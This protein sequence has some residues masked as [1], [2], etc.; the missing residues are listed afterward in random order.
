MDV[1]NNTV[2]YVDRTLAVAIAAK[3]VGVLQTQTEGANRSA[4]F[5]WL[6]SAAVGS[7]NT[8][9]RASD[10][11]ELLPEDLIYFLYPHIK[12]R[13]ASVEP[14]I[15]RLSSGAGDAFTPGTPISICGE[16]SFPSLENLPTA[17]K[18]YEGV[19]IDLPQVTFHGEKCV[20][21]QLKS[22]AFVVPVFFEEAA[23]YQV[24]FCHE[25]PVEVTGILRWT[26][27]YSPR[28]GRALNMAIRSAALW[29]R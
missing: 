22:G 24:A 25:Q 13:H 18:P 9:A 17:Y 1:K 5:N 4:S 2:V 14:V 3:L 15:G 16:L 26:P 21:A 27:P 8:S 7:Q 29:L 28:G 19:E 6:V 11:R 20:V 10:V 12:E 23:K